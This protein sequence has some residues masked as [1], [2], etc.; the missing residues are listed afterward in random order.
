MLKLWCTISRISLYSLSSNYHFFA[1]WLMFLIDT[2][3]VKLE[4][5]DRTRIEAWI[6][7]KTSFQYWLSWRIFQVCIWFLSAAESFL[8]LGLYPEYVVRW[9][10]QENWTKSMALMISHIWFLHIF[11]ISFSSV[12]ALNYANQLQIFPHLHLHEILS[13]KHA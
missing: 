1:F 6:D 3:S 9:L 4:D 7:L 12:F 13:I 5:A 10:G 8:A 2:R 11:S